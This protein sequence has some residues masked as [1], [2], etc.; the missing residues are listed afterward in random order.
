MRQLATKD[1][2]LEDAGY[3]YNLER[4]L[5]VNRLAKR[6]FSIE[7]VQDHSEEDIKDC[8]ERETGD[9]WMFY[10]NSKPSDFVRRE[11][12]RLLT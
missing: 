3:V 4:A 1:Q 10:F 5:Y 9:S 2:L 7:F 11:L 12:E 8:I 6:A